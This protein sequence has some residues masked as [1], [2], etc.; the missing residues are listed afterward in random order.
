MDSVFVSVFV[1][2]EVSEA[3]FE[4]S[5]REKGIWIPSIIDDSDDDFDEAMAL[6]HIQAAMAGGTPLSQIVLEDREADFHNI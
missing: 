3:L 4:A 6:K 1:D 2:D 5:L